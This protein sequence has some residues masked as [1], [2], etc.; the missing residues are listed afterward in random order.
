[1]S[2]RLTLKTLH[3]IFKRKDYECELVKAN[4][5]LPFDR[6]RLNLGNSRE[7]QPLLLTMTTLDYPISWD[8]EKGEDEQEVA[9][10]I[11]FLFPLNIFCK[12]ETLYEVNRLL[13]IYNQSIQF[14]G[15]CLAEKEQ[16]VCYMQELY[17]PEG[18]VNQK[19]LMGLI[20]HMVVI[21]ES[22]GENIEQVALGNLTTQ[23]IVAQHQEDTTST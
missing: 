17:V 19:L 21:A 8:E 20:G 18:T 6:L 3:H 11:R 22:L 12:D 13:N 10:F 23:D 16:E 9:C 14:P 2:S 5:E 4:Q 7:G 15:L 1:M